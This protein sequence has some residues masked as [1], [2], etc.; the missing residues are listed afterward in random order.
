M[1]VLPKHYWEGREFD[2]TTLEPPL[3]SG[4]YRIK[5]VDAGRGIAYERVAGLLGRRHAGQQRPQ[6]F[7]RAA[8]RVLSR[9]E[10]RPRGVQGRPDRSAAREQLALL[11]HRLRGAG[12]RAGADHQAEIPTEGGN[13]MQGFVFNTRRA[14]VRGSAGAAGARLRVRFRVDQ[15]ELCSTASTP[16]PTSY[17][18]NSELAAHGLPGPDELALL[19]PFRDRLPKEVFDQEFK[20]PVTDGSGN[21]RDNLRSGRGPVARR[22]ATRSAAA[23]WSTP[24]P[25]SRWRSRS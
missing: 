22:P 23:S 10:R 18:S 20:L 19:E 2:R 4:P 5:S 3:G 17:F 24:R 13:G 12:A 7:R 16:A 14:E 6:Q 9:P 8:L 21:N 1:P 15:Q 25:A 11:G